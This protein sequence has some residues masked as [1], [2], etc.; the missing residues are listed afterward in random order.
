MLGKNVNNFSRFFSS[1]DTS[2]ICNEKSIY[3]VNES[4]DKEVYI[5]RRENGE[6][7][8]KSPKSLENS[9]SGTISVAFKRMFI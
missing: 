8:K 7:V 6:Y 3:V 4:S 2:K 9:N 1:K 5:R